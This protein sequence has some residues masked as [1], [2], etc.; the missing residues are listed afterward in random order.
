MPQ[1]RGMMA[2]EVKTQW[3]YLLPT[4]CCSD[5]VCLDKPVLWIQAE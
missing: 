1:S 2:D 3:S 5:R 4:V